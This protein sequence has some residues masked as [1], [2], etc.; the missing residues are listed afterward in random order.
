MQAEKIRGCSKRYS[1]SPVKGKCKPPFK[2]SGRLSARPIQ[3]PKPRT[4]DLFPKSRTLLQRR[5]RSRTRVPCDLPSGKYPPHASEKS[6]YRKKK[7][8][9]PP[10]DPNALLRN[11]ARVS[12]S[13][14]RERFSATRNSNKSICSEA[15]IAET[16]ITENRTGRESG[17]P[18]FPPKADCDFPAAGDTQDWL[19]RQYPGRPRCPH[20]CEETGLPDPRWRRG[21]NRNCLCHLFFAEYPSPRAPT[22]VYIGIEEEGGQGASFNDGEDG[23]EAILR[24]P[25][26]GHFGAKWYSLSHLKH[27]SPL[28]S[29]HLP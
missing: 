7:S 2:K 6:T 21:T 11:D 23:A 14:G 17:K 8:D 27:R 18:L 25:P 15:K 16:T 22:G 10:G 24:S 29:D 3:K 4:S 13:K 9:W 19:R 1:P 26:K 28:V 12:A 5:L 20:Q